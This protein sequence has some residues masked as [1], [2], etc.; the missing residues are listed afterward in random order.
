MFDIRKQF[1]LSILKYRKRIQFSYK[2]KEDSYVA[3][4]RYATKEND[5]QFKSLLNVRLSSMHKTR[6]AIPLTQHKIAVHHC[7]NADK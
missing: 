1:F 3:M 5:M 2:L 4:R 7:S 6:V